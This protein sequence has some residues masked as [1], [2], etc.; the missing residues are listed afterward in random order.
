M[1]DGNLNTSSSV[2][3]GEKSLSYQIGPAT[4]LFANWRITEKS[5]YW[6]GC[7]TPQSEQGYTPV[8]QTFSYSTGYN[9]LDCSN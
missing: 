1:C 8:I 2:H 7:T 3:Y 9:W 5:V 4:V 6:E